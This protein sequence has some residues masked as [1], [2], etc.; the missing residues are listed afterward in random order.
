[1][2]EKGF[3]LE[4]LWEK[5]GFLYEN[6]NDFIQINENS[7]EQVLGAMAEKVNFIFDQT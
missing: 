2:K 5:R 4:K 7:M 6:F 1:M 3:A